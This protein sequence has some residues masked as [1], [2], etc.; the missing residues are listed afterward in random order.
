[1][2]IEYFIL[3]SDQKIEPKKL[4]FCK[5]KSMNALHQMHD[6]IVSSSYHEGFIRFCQL[7]YDQFR[8]NHFWYYR[9]NVTG[10]YC[11]MGTHTAWTE[12][13]FDAL[14]NL[15]D[16]PCLRHPSILQSG[17]NFMKF[18]SSPEYEDLLQ[19]AWNK[20][21]ISFSLNLLNKVEK[22]IEAFGFAVEINDPQVDQMLFNDL[23][24]LQ[25]FIKTLRQRH[26]KL[27]D[28]LYEN[29]VNLIPYFGSAFYEHSS[30][31]A[32]PKQE[33]E[34]LP[35]IGYAWILELTQREL[36]VLKF[37]AQGYPSPYIASKL[38]LRRRTVENYTAAIKDKLA[39]TSKFELIEKTSELLPLVECLLKK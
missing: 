1:M 36:G 15:K 38:N 24:Y 6:R 21:S 12:F 5:I 20:F 29:Q 13:S 16:F 3:Y 25:P 39:V 31:F 18:S 37:L 8:I 14:Q 35:K 27:F 23:P 32:F 4:F 34:I 22:G 2:Q 10:D 11:Y 19:T 26:R 28:F 7:L 17:I 9:I 33:K 30:M